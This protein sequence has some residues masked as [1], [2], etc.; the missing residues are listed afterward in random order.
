MLKSNFK[1]ALRSFIKNPGFA[2]TALI[3]LALGIGANT[4][5]FS[6]IYGVLLHNLPYPDANRLVV[7]AETLGEGKTR[8]VS[9]PNYLDWKSEDQVFEN[10]AAYSS[11]NLNLRF[12]DRTERIP[13]EFVSDSYFP[14]LGI[15]PHSGRTFTKP[16]NDE[17]GSH[18]VVVLS[19]GCWQRRFGSDSNLIGKNLKLNGTDFTVIGIMPKEF[20]G[21]SGE[22]DLWLP[23]GMWDVANPEIAQ[24]DFLH[25]RDI[26][27]HQVLGRLKPGI[28]LN[29]VRT[30]MQTI[31]VHL[32]KAYPGANANRGIR[33]E[34]AQESLVGEIRSP[35][36]ILLG[37]VAFILLIACA[38]VANL[39]L[40]RAAERKRE[41]AIR[42]A[43]GASRAQLVAQ[44]IT[45]STLLTVTGGCVGL[46]FAF[47]G[48]DLLS[49]F[50]PSDVLLF[51]AIRINV[52]VLAFTM[53]LALVTGILLGLAPAMQTYS[54]HLS[55]SLEEGSARAGRRSG[56]R[57]ALVVAEISLAL[58]LMIGAGL[59]LKSFQQ[60]RST[61]LGFQ[62]DHLLTMRFDVPAEKYSG[63][64]RANAAHR[65]LKQ[66]QQIPGVVSAGMN[67]ADLF[68]WMASSVALRF[69]NVLL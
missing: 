33:I 23:M 56:A 29:Q 45:E 22:T 4:A 37:A 66:V 54:K 8:P 17:L 62:P 20:R 24:F 30:R 5:V 35:L 65:L 40:F 36:Y 32:E 53:I 60:L 46:L 57:N 48:I 52:A 2:L 51:S 11:E 59:L 50:L 49:L 15:S 42:Q 6:L 38:N 39:M 67:T 34:Q 9:Y 69:R 13:G 47:W 61:H 14:V 21:F 31:A 28:T 18:P 64:D 44:L 10:L 12:K 25:A 3:T 1:Y 16:E 19:Y 27:W 43:L 63:A 41:I 26:H 58:V 55:L 68:C 7:V